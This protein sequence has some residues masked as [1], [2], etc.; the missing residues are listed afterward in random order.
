MNTILVNHGRKA[1]TAKVAV[2]ALLAAFVALVVGAGNAKAANAGDPIDV[3][4]NYAGIYVELAAL[5]EVDQLLDSA[6]DPIEMTGTYSD[7]AGNFSVPK[8]GGL[9]F[10]TIAVPVGPAQ[11]DGDIAL[12]EDGTGNY[13]ESTGAMSLDLKISLTLGVDD[14]SA[15]PSEVATILGGGSGPLTCVFSPID[16]SLSTSG[17]WPHPGKVF[18]DKAALTDGALAGAWLSKPDVTQLAG[19]AGTCDLIANVLTVV[20]GIWLANSTATIDEENWA[21]ATDPKPCPAGQVR[22]ELQACVEPEEEKC[23]A[24][25]TGTP[26]KCQKN[27]APGKVGSLTITKKKTVK[28]GK[29]VKIKIK[30]KNTG[31]KTFTGKINLKSNKK[32]VKVPKSI[33]V[34]IGA[35]KTVTKTITVK[36]TKK[37]KGKAKITAKIGGKTA[38]SVITVKAV[39]KKKKKANKKANKK[40]NKKSGKRK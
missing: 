31:G 12:I 39:K 27:V 6:A 19:R 25:T 22:N 5:G 38:K 37:A 8:T 1:L 34:S 2:A 36:T 20:G 26:P 23:P 7:S 3:D 17:G 29:N 40:G 4:Y 14:M 35:K 13:N 11:I 30:V 24:G 16:I 15:L 18:G 21:D 32:T 9:A 33:S 28:A 10:P